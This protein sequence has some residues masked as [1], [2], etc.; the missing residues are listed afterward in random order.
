MN[1]PL[2]KHNL[3]IGFS[4][5]C[6]QD[7]FI[8]TLGYNDFHFIAPLKVPRVQSIN[9]LHLILNGSGTLILNGKKFRLKEQDLFF[10]PPDTSLCYYPDSGNEWSYIWFE[11]T[12][13][14]SEKYASYM[15]FDINNPFRQCRNFKNFYYR[16]CSMIKKLEE[17]LSIGYYEILSLFYDLL[18]SNL[19]SGSEPPKNYAD[20][21]MAYIDCHYHNNNLSIENLCRDLNVSHSYLCRTFK[22]HTGTSVIR[23]LVNYRI[24]KAEELLEKTDLSVKEIAYSVGFND[25]LHFMKSFKK[26]TGLSAGEYRRKK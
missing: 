7:F 25:C 3:Y 12:G 20:M 14:N 21:A 6:E 8:H 9:T 4:D 24:E 19:Q 5:C 26:Q 22:A 18:N 15:G 16:I 11:F 13:K 23:Y 1:K 2:S 10:I 17:N